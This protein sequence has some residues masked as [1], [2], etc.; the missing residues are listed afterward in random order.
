[1][2]VERRLDVGV[3]RADLGGLGQEIEIFLCEGAKSDQALPTGSVTA[4]VGPPESTGRDRS[5]AGTSTLTAP[6]LAAVVFVAE[7]CDEP[8]GSAARSG[9]RRRARKVGDFMRLR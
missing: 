8:A 1:M 9:A 3:E 7:A 2:V 5:I 4:G 6:D